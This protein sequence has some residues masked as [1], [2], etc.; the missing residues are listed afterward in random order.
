MC[1][2]ACIYKFT[3]THLH[4]CVTS[5]KSLYIYICVCAC[6]YKF[7]GTHLHTCVTSFKKTF[8]VYDLC[9]HFVLGTCSLLKFSWSRVSSTCCNMAT[10]D[11]GPLAGLLIEKLNLQY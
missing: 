10:V 1:V 6:I 8:E 11:S 9:A 7:T 5:F 3:G 2:C 4:T